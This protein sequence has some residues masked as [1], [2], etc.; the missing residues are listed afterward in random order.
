M[1][2]ITI[3]VSRNGKSKNLKLR[4]SEG[5]RDPDGDKITTVVN[6]GDTVIWE[7]DPD[8]SNLY[9][10]NGIEKKASSEADLLIGHPTLQSNGSYKGTVKNDPKLKG[11]K[12][13]YYI[14]YK[15]K[16]DGTIQADDPK[17]RM[18]K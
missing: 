5:N 9:S 7:L 10:L 1:A 12:E 14:R 4:D 8:G 6:L 15:I 3:Y 13:S 11:K 16:E 17:L 18:K 2:E